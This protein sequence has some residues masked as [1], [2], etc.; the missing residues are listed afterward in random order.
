VHGTCVLDTGC[1]YDTVHRVADYY[2]PRTAFTYRRCESDSALRSPLRHRLYAPELQWQ[3]TGTRRVSQGL[4]CNLRRS[5]RPSPEPN[6]ALHQ[7]CGRPPD[8]DAGPPVCLQ[9]SCSEPSAS[10]PYNQ[11]GQA[12][13]QLTICSRFIYSSVLLVS[14]CIVRVCAYES[15]PRTVSVR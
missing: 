6:R 4:G 11:L 10:K 8:P 15:V 9:V 5:R 3:S 13:N 7:L 12:T 1:W 14:P 2:R